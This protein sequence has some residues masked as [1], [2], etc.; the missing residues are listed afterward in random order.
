MKYQEIHFDTIDSTNKYIKEHYQTL[1]DFSIVSSD[2][3]SLGKGRN[4]RSWIANKGDNLL[5]SLLIKNKDITA[6]GGYLSLVAAISVVQ[7]LEKRGFAGVFIKW[8]N[9]IYLADKKVVGIL[10]E[11]Q[12]PDYLI[13]GIGINVNQEE[14]KGDYRITPTSL[15][16]QKG[17]K[18]DINDFKKEVFDNLIDNVINTNE[19]KALFKEYFSKHN[20]LK[21][22]EIKYIVSGI[23]KSGK[24]VDVD[25]DFHLLVEK[26]GETISLNSG[27]VNLIH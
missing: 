17:E 5:F 14:F 12:L 4:D 19:N 16:L 11:G 24:V 7:I 10:L 1:D 25:E 6:N 15:Y 13:I 18:I 9:D 23:E 8:P 2:Y 3:Q 26:E 20:Y 22:K 21:D 27:E